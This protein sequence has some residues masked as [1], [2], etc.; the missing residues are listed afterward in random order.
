M[1]MALI[2]HLSSAPPPQTA[3][4]F[5]VL[6]EIKVLHIIEYAGLAA[7]ILFAVHNTADLPFKWAAAYSIM[8]TYIYGL[9]D[10][11]H[12]VFVPCRGPSLIDPF[13]NLAAAYLAMAAVYYL[14]G[15]TNRR[16]RS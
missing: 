6:F 9:T 11:L 15:K 16:R 8:L 13:A 14:R 1:Y 5:P 12:Q 4:A 3:R 7:L 10:E 2:Y